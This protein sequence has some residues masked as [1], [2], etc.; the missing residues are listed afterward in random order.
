[1]PSRLVL[2]ATIARVPLLRYCWKQYNLSKKLHVFNPE[3]SFDDHLSVND[4]SPV[5]AL[6]GEMLAVQS[7]QASVKAM[8]DNAPFSMV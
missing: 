3:M 6:C 1:M 7:W 4:V 2:I 8:G 5:T